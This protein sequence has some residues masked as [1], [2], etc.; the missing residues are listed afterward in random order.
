MDNAIKVLD[1]GIAALDDYMGSDLKIVKNARVSFDKDNLAGADVFKDENLIN[2]LMDNRHTTPFESVVFTFYIK[3]PIFVFRQWHRHRT[4]SYNEVSSRYTQLPDEFYV[5][6]VEHV[7]VQSKSNKQGRDLVQSSEQVGETFRTHLS[8]HCQEGFR[9]YQHHLSEGVPR[10]ESRFFLGVNTYSKMYATVNLHNL[11]HFLGLRLHSHAQY[12]IRVYAEAML[13]LIRPIVPI[14]VKRFEWV[15]TKN[16][17][18]QEFLNQ[19]R[20]AEREQF[21]K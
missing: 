7:G 12:E 20:K 3:A 21:A 8:L 16:A 11:F 9:L 4:W 19:E 10:E 1:H 5:P 15:R 6:K 13:E 14:A 2:Y 17:K 18:Y